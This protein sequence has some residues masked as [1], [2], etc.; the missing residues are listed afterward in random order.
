M[1]GRTEALRREGRENASVTGAGDEGRGR[2][3]RPEWRVCGVQVTSGLVHRTL[4]FG[5][6]PEGRWKPLEGFE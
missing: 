4:G 5:I 2:E 6:Y 1:G 3:R